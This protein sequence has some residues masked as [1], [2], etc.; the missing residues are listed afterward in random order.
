MNLGKPRNPL[1]AQYPNQFIGL[2]LVRYR[3]D[4]RLVA[5]NL[6]RKLLHIS[7]GGQSGDLKPSLKGLD[8]RQALPANRSRRTQY[9]E[10]L[11]FTL[12][13]GSQMFRKFLQSYYILG[14]YTNIQ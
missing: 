8:H 7:T 12:L 14:E 6:I 1:L 4:T 11:H 3:N 13:L 9:R 10:T 2:R 5:P